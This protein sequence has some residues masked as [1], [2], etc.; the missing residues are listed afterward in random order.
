[1]FGVTLFPI[2]GLI[3]IAILF[4]LGTVF[5]NVEAAE[6]ERQLEEIE[7]A[8]AATAE[9][10]RQH[11]ETATATAERER[12][13]RETAATALTRAEGVLNKQYEPRDIARNDNGN[14]KND[15]HERERFQRPSTPAHNN[16]YRPAT[17]VHLM[18]PI[19]GNELQHHSRIGS[20][21]GVP[22]YR[23]LNADL[24]RIGSETDTGF[25][26]FNELTETERSEVTNLAQC[27]IGVEKSLLDPVLARINATGDGRPTQYVIGRFDKSNDGQLTAS[28]KFIRRSFKIKD[29]T[30]KLCRFARF[31][32]ISTGGGLYALMFQDY[33]PYVDEH[34]PQFD[35]FYMKGAKERSHWENLVVTLHYNSVPINISHM[36]ILIPG[37]KHNS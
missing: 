25:K 5:R 24:S 30:T 1:M 32:I 16:H 11:R 6:H 15:V 14:Y 37:G 26:T 3:L 17:P 18:R 22:S 28:H 2:I 8:T 19:S 34:A 9:R 35:V 21:T 20:P 12:Q 36:L 4:V 31:R 33:T 27:M 23:Q 29:K 10:E 7:E 13:R